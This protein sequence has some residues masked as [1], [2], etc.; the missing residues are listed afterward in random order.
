MAYGLYE[1]L[2]EKDGGGPSSKLADA[3]LF[4]AFHSLKQALVR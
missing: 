4:R 3:L 1:S 2:P